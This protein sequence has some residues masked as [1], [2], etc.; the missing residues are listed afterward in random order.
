MGKLS[1]LLGGS[2][3]SYFGYSLLVKSE[4]V[5]SQNEKELVAAHI[6]QAKR[7]WNSTVLESVQ[8]IL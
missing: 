5:F 7:K 3:L 4:L 1:F 8:K 2:I 6:H